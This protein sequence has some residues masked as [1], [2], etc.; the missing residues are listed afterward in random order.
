[1]PLGNWFKPPPLR[2]D[3][4]ANLYVSNIETAEAWYR[5]SLGFK[6][7]PMTDGDEGEWSDVEAAIVCKFKQ[8]E[9]EPG[10]YVMKLVAGADDGT[11]SDGSDAI[12]ICR[13]LSEAADLLTWRG[14]S[15]GP[16]QEDGDGSKF[17]F[18]QDPDGNKLQVLEG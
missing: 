13:N 9:E 15:V 18:V 7:R 10:I 17:F 6:T 3:D 5:E 12:F 4:N 16:V 1:M 8:E 11:R 14:V 2:L